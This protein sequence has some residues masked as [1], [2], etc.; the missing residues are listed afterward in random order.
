M[1]GICS[2]VAGSLD[3]NNQKFNGIEYNTDFDIN[4]YDAFYRNLDPQIGRF[5]QIDP[6]PRFEESTYSAM[7]NNPILNIDP[8]GDTVING[9]KY[10]P[11]SPKHGTVLESV[12][13]IGTR[14]LPRKGIYTLAFTS[15]HI[16]KDNVAAAQSLWWN[17]VTKDLHRQQGQV[18][19]SRSGI[20]DFFIGHREIPDP[21]YSEDDIE[22][23]Y[24]TGTLTIGA[25]GYIEGPTINYQGGT[26]PF[27]L[28]GSVIPSIT[29]RASSLSNKIGKFSI[30]IKTPKGHIR[31]DLKGAKHGKIPTPH[32]LT[33]TRHTGSNGKINFTHPKDPTF[34][35]EQDL[36]I[37]R[38]Y[39][40]SLK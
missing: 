30:T 34:M 28:K 25:D 3:Y 27:G 17:S 26:A 1:A 14:I 21:D 10:E 29:Q 23:Q 13:V 11:T 9:Q 7:S 37:L 15:C 6:R 35:T 32:S 8:L 36:R 24:N 31:F 19:P 12:T 39:F 20:I 22:D 5:W 16:P 2:K 18:M 33:Y 38:N 40:K 4:T